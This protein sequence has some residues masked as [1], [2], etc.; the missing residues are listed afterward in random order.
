MDHKA[1]LIQ[2][3]N[4]K[5]AEILDT[6]R[7]RTQRIE[8]FNKDLEDLHKR[9]RQLVADIPLVEI[10][11]LPSSVDGEVHND[12][13]FS[14]KLFGNVIRINVSEDAG[15]L[16]VK[17]NN[18]WSRDTFLVPVKPTVWSSTAKAGE[19]LVLSDNT[20]LERLCEF[21]DT[22]IAKSVNLWD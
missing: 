2:K 18:V 16:G 13:C 14:I 10:E 9:L 4:E 21:V 6:A 15:S 5:N 20:I 3:I 17:V 1:R 19:R 11:T 8:S 22:P 12:G 7:N